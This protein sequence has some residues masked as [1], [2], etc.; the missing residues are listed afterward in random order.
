MSSSNCMHNFV[1]KNIIYKSHK[2]TINICTSCSFSNT[3]LNNKDEHFHSW[4]VFIGKNKHNFVLKCSNIIC[5]ER[6]EYNPNYQDDR[7]QH[8]NYHKYNYSTIR[9]PPLETIYE[10]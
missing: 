3:K 1:Q 5:G 4:N 10:H 9:S 8:N 2:Y 6:I 7:A